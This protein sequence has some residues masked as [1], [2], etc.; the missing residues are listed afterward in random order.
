[1]TG[2]CGLEPIGTIQVSPPL[3][4]SPRTASLIRDSLRVLSSILDETIAIGLQAQPCACRGEITTASRS[5][6]LRPQWA[7]E[8]VSYGIGEMPGAH[9]RNRGRASQKRMGEKSQRRDPAEFR[10]STEHHRPRADGTQ[11]NGDGGG[12]QSPQLGNQP[13]VADPV[14][15]GTHSSHPGLIPSPITEPRCNHLDPS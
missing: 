1:V 3:R 12:Q 9:H 4:G 6:R 13:P 10:P 2:D 5:S 7:P 14:R 11:S 15:I 8:W